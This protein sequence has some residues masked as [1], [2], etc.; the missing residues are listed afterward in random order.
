MVGSAMLKTR[1][2]AYPAVVYVIVFDCH[3]PLRVFR[4]KRGISALDILSC[5]KAQWL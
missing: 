3:N 4:S 2:S 5:K 1:I